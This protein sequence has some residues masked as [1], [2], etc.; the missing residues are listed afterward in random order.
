MRPRAEDLG[1]TDDADATFGQQ[2]R[3]GL[4][5]Q[6]LE[7]GLQLIRLGLEGQRTTRGHPQGNDAEP[8]LDRMPQLGSQASAAGEQFGRLE[9]VEAAAQPLGALTSNALRWQIARVR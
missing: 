2:H 1:R 4:S 7:L 3:R 8:M 9:A 6:L 5:D